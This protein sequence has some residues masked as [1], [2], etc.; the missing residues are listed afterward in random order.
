MIR[1]GRSI[2]V[3]GLLSIS[4]L[5]QAAP[6]ANSPTTPSSPTSPPAVKVILAY[7]AK[8]GQVT[9]S[10]SQLVIK[11]NEG[12]QSVQLTYKQTERNTYTNIAANGDITETEKTESGSVEVMGHTSQMPASQETTDT[13]VY[14]PQGELVSYKSG[15]TSSTAD[16]SH[17]N[18]R[19]YTSTTP[20]FETT[21]VGVGDSWT[22]DVASNSALGLPSGHGTYKV[23]DVETINNAPVM[24]IHEHYDES[25]A[26]HPISVDG[27]VWVEESSGDSVKEDLQVS[28]LPGFDKTP[29]T[30]HV[31]GER[32]EGSPLGDV[33][34]GGVASASKTPKPK[35]IADEVKGYTK[36]PGLFTLYRK[37]KGTSDSI[38]MEVKDSQLNKPFLMEVTARTGDSQDI[39]AGTPINDLLLEFQKSPDGRLMITTP[40]INFRATP[41]TPMDLAV[42]RS[43][44]NGRLAIFDIKAKDPKTSM[45][46]DV[47]ELF[48]GNFAEVS[49]ALQGSALSGLLGGGGGGYSIDSEK[50]FITEVKSYPDNVLVE[51]SYNFQKEGGPSGGLG[52]NLGSLPLLPDSRSL[53]VTIDYTIFGL[54]NDGFMPRIADPRIGYFQ[55][56]YQDFD[57][58]NKSNQMVHYIYHWN[59]QKKDPSA[60][61]SPPVKPIVFWLDKAIPTEYRGPIRHALLEWNKAFLAI[62]IDNAIVVHQMPDNAKWDTGDMRYN[63]VRWVVSPG[64]GYA[65]SLMRVNP[66]TGEILNADITVD[67]NL[68]RFTKVDKTLVVDP[69]RYFEDLTTPYNQKALIEQSEP[70]NCKFMQ[71]GA[72]DAWEG[73]LALSLL[74]PA[75]QSPIE[76]KRYA[77][78]YIR[79]AVSH[80]MGH[81]LGLRHNFVGSTF[82]TMAQLKDAKLMLS[83]GISASV[84]DYVPF[85][86]EALKHPGVPFWQ[87]T[88]GVYDKW[89]IKYGYMPIPATTPDG[90][91][92][93]L[94]Q[95]ASDS[96]APGHPLESDG[97]VNQ[98]DPNVTQFDLGKDP[99]VYWHKMLNLSRFLMLS[100][101]HRVPAPGRSYSRFTTDLYALISQY[102]QAGSEIGRYIGGLHV[103]RNFRGDAGEVPTLMPIKGATQRD[104]LNIIDNYIL[105]PVAFK[106]P[107]TYYTHLTMGQDAGIIAEL[108]GQDY[109]ILNTITNLQA[110]ALNYLLS[111]SV[112]GRVANNEYKLGNTPGKFTQA[113]LFHNVTSTVW[114]GLQSG[115]NFDTLQRQLQRNYLDTMSNIVLGKESVPGDSKMLAWYTLNSLK[116]SL[117]T[118]STKPHDLYT[119]LQIEQSLMIVNRVLN[120]K[121]VIGGNSGGSQP[122]LLQLLLGGTKGH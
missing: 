42:K 58:D 2:P 26:D 3:L 74:D 76:E 75:S 11:L 50:T 45:L 25:G 22:H 109:P 44:A 54:K 39:V 21:A 66:M 27:D 87:N 18:E 86:I 85:N 34:T 62:G 102:S 80:E 96:N 117:Q 23:V 110:S 113:E 55:V 31:T 73:G 120:A 35:T 13:I 114:Q 118:A 83:Q 72:T 63:V 15:D 51:T 19:L 10:K 103:S 91:L 41:G 104:A 97:L 106:L 61:L 1:F 93:E 92:Y 17:L 33:V 32:I 78:E 112:L 67:A 71:E 49:D 48:R 65:V 107:E 100:L 24:K 98:F 52:V 46:I 82:H 81:I 79:M 53:P 95:I 9:R 7:K 119:K 101:F 89:A 59:I 12:G 36:I 57:N 90:Q 43:F 99:M 105:S 29:V 77:Q 94:H 47:S 28:N 56:S 122:N 88:I 84:M 111:P 37:Q 121:Q 64:S 69:A 6:Q 38:Y 14:S 115:K 20:W 8:V 4:A 60:K 70:W 116:A 108:S 16:K 40:N 5:T 68:V 30:A